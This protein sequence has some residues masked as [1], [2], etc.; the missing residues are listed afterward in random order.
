MLPVIP[1]VVTV[2]AASGFALA[3][4]VELGWQSRWLRRLRGVRVEVGG[5]SSGEPTNDHARQSDESGD[6]S[7]YDSELELGVQ[8]MYTEEEAAAI[9]ES[10]RWPYN[11]NVQYLGW[12]DAYRFPEYAL[13]APRFFDTMDAPPPAGDAPA[14]VQDYFRPLPGPGKLPIKGFNAEPE[15]WYP[16]NQRAQRGQLPQ[17]TN[18]ITPEVLQHQQGMNEQQH[19]LAYGNETYLLPS[20]SGEHNV[21]QKG[22]R[23]EAGDMSS[24][25]L[26]RPSAATDEHRQLGHFETGPH[27]TAFPASNMR[28]RTRDPSAKLDQLSRFQVEPTFDAGSTPVWEQHVR[29]TKFRKEGDW[30]IP[31]LPTADPLMATLNSR[32]QIVDEDSVLAKRQNFNDIFEEQNAMFQASSTKVYQSDAGTDAW[33]AAQQDQLF[34]TRPE[35]LAER[36]RHSDMDGAVSAKLRAQSSLELIKAQ[37][38]SGVRDEARRK[39]FARGD[40]E[41]HMDGSTVSGIVRPMDGLLRRLEGRTS[42]DDDAL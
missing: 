1:V 38:A 36:V 34:G 25:W 29:T 35:K 2:A 12:P 22:I 40:I 33:H 24:D 5:D 42:D 16:R 15:A 3:K 18:H 23:S 7:D 21:S 9:P 17:L 32:A 6:E 37:E 41:L 19:Q 13:R 39:R 20:A 26:K 28:V 30:R 14:Q 4:T 10:E 27:L 31:L 8:P 11:S